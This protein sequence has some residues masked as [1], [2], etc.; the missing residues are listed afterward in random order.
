MEGTDDVETRK[1][2][3]KDIESDDVEQTIVPDK[4]VTPAKKSVE[5][6]DEPDDDS[7][8]NYDN[9]EAR[10]FTIRKLHAVVTKQY[11]DIEGLMCE[12]DVLNLEISSPTSV[13]RFIS[14]QGQ[15]AKNLSTWFL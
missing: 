10:T 6:R 3:E 4:I 14:V 12:V 9:R 2:A 1:V 13:R 8:D 5:H 15:N 7:N 11:R